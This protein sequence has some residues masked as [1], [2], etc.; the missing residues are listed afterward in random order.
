LT[1]YQVRAFGQEQSFM[2]STPMSE[3]DIEG[4]FCTT[5]PFVFT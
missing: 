3:L 5:T 4:L 2:Q 1:F